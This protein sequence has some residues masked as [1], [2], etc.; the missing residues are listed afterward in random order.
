MVEEGSITHISSPRGFSALS[1]LFLLMIFD[2]FVM[3]P[4]G[5]LG[6]FW[7]SLL[8][9]GTSLINKL[10][11][12]RVTLI[13]EKF[14]DQGSKDLIQLLSF[15]RG[16]FPFCLFECSFIKRCTKACLAAADGG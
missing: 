16:K 2:F 15:Q 5:T 12:R 9:M 10:I 3:V 13:L 8:F 11:I 1:Y 4:G 7:M 6:T 14:S